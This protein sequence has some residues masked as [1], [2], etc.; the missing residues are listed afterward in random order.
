MNEMQYS[1]DQ[2]SPP[3]PKVQK[4]MAC[5]ICRQ[6]KIKCDGGLPSCSVCTKNKQQC[7]Y[8][9]SKRRGRPSRSA[10]P[11]ER[12]LEALPKLLPKALDLIANPDIKQLRE[13]SPASA[14]QSKS[15]SPHIT[16]NNFSLQQNSSFNFNETLNQNS[17]VSENYITSQQ[18][19]NTQNSFD[20]NN[21]T[22]TFENETT[23]NYPL[24]GNDPKDQNINGFDIINHTFSP[25]SLYNNGIDINLAA[26]PDLNVGM[27]VDLDDFSLASIARHIKTPK[28]PTDYYY[29]QTGSVFNDPQNSFTY[30]KQQTP[31]GIKAIANCFTKRDYPEDLNVP[32]IPISLKSKA[33]NDP[34]ILLYF[35]N[36]N[37]QFPIIHYP[38]FREEYDDGT[39][40]NYLVM[41]MQ[42]VAS[43]YSKR[44][45]VV[46]SDELN[47]AGVDQAAIATSLADLVTQ[48][49]PNT[50][51]IQTLLILS[52]FE[53]GLGKST[54]AYDRRN[55]AIKI[56]RNLGI[57]TLDSGGR[58]KH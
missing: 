22:F 2:S 3:P 38:S 15:L 23:T 37:S 55:S 19:I 34:L 16:P 40:P 39:I 10:K 27:D 41:A 33:Y 20:Y 43:R 49:D 11:P 6:K 1:D 36:F 58:T 44:P 28:L 32:M 42:A 56:A 26:T 14:Q 35:Y 12:K 29:K 13:S 31:Y 4:L 8:V 53:F 24:L 7:I 50:S 57:D 54:K 47:T 21:T 25:N 5:T 18:N 46:I 45:S 9:L 52:I 51:L 48:Q 17:N 30:A